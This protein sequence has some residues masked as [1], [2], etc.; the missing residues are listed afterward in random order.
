MNCTLLFADVHCLV[1]PLL[2]AHPKSHNSL[3]VEFQAMDQPRSEMSLLPPASQLPWQLQLLLVPFCPD[4]GEKKT[5]LSSSPF[6]HLVSSSR[7]LLDTFASLDAVKAR[8]PQ[9]L[10][11]ELGVGGGGVPKGLKFFT[12]N[13]QKSYF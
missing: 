2:V 9:D 8:G 5:M 7:W 1:V 11:P 12:N 4:V 6:V 10:N 3:V 13:R